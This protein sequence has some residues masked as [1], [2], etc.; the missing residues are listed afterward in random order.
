MLYFI[1]LF[2]E[3]KRDNLRTRCSPQGFY[4]SYATG[5]SDYAGGAHNIILLV[6]AFNTYFVEHIYNVICFQILFIFA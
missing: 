4:F 2:T 3:L 1:R 5:S 6:S